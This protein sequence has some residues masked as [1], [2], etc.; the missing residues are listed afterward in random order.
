M[1][2]RISSVLNPTSMGS[3]AVEDGSLLIRLVDLDGGNSPENHVVQAIAVTAGIYSE[4]SGGS[5]FR[6]GCNLNGRL[7]T[8]DGVC[9]VGYLFL[10]APRAL[11]CGS[12][13]AGE[14]AN[15]ALLDWNGDTGL[16]I[17][18]ATALLS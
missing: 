5:R 3:V 13:A 4:A 10:G 15:R 9:Q 17:S 1:Q 18:D 12:G 14:P 6:G 11:P 8:S 16:D 7:D 2:R